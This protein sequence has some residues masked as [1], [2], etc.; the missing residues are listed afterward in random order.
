M[1]IYTEWIEQLATDREYA[2]TESQRKE[3]DEWIQ[4]IKLQQSKNRNSDIVVYHWTLEGVEHGP[5]S[6]AYI[7]KAIRCQEG[8]YPD[9]EEEEGPS[10]LDHID[11]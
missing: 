10:T 3:Y 1:K 5:K 2:K 11:V 7:S 8:I 6:L 9:L 4:W